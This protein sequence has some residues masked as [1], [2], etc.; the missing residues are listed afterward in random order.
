MSGPAERPTEGATLSRRTLGLLGLLCVG[1]AVQNLWAATHPFHPD[2]LDEGLNLEY[3]VL[4]RTNLWLFVH[5]LFDESRVNTV[6]LTYQGFSYGPW[7]YLTGAATNLTLGKA[8]W[9]TLL[10]VQAGVCLGLVSTF[11]LVLRLSGREAPAWIATA[12]LG[13]AP[14]VL[15]Y[16]RHFTTDT[17]VLGWTA[18]AAAVLVHT[19]GFQRWRPTLLLGVVG[20]C[21]LLTKIVLP[22]LLAFPLVAYFYA[23]VVRGR[24]FPGD[25]APPAGDDVR[26]RLR[27]AAGP[28]LV[29]SA[30]TAALAWLYLRHAA[31]TARDAGL[32][33]E[34][35]RYNLDLLG[36][37]G[38]TA[39]EAYPRSDS[40]GVVDWLLFYPNMLF[41]YQ[42]GVPLTILC[43]G[44]AA[45]GLARRVPGVGWTA[46]AWAFAMLLFTGLV[47]KKWYYTLPA[48][49][50][51]AAA[52]ALG[53]ERL[54]ASSGRPRL[55]RAAVVAPILATGL[56]VGWYGRPTPVFNQP[57]L[58]QIAPRPGAGHDGEAV[59]AFRRA[60]EAERVPG[61]EG[62]VVLLSDVPFKRGHGGGQRG[63]YAFLHEL[64][65]ALTRSP[66]PIRL[67]PA[68]TRSALHWWLFPG[69]EREWDPAAFVLYASRDGSTWLDREKLD[70]WPAWGTEGRWLDEAIDRRRPEAVTS[71]SPE[72]RDA[73]ILMVGSRVR[74]LERTTVAD[75]Q[76]VL[77]RIESPAATR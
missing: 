73:A 25:P 61:R 75:W 3:L 5:T 69:D 40:W 29:G 17:W 63:V 72:L 38:I 26:A 1:Y 28:F 15:Y 52:A 44:G 46:G 51:L 54:A 13:C 77:S 59:R 53:I 12:L 55:L 48:L 70:G 30:I 36:V 14:M 49:P 45:W 10:T 8:P 11:V 21:G 9:V 32:S 27:L 71:G 34:A 68:E 24:A 23:T 2:A 16:G 67:Q 47:A 43:L 66:P 6:G 22:H 33:A 57:A 35:A 74:E 31:G 20:G 56:W 42:L 18:A 62:T 60:I 58:L 65:A 39:V 4:T 41:R 50:F 7:L 19:R 64:Q 76:L 37:W